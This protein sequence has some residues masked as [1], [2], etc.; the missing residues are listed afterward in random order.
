[1]KSTYIALHDYGAGG[2][3]YRLFA[4]S[5]NDVARLFP[6]PAWKVVREG[7]PGCPSLLPELNLLESD[8]DEPEDW[9]QKH[10]WRLSQQKMGRLPFYFE[11]RVS[12]IYKY[13]E[14]WAE[15]ESQV[16]LR[17]PMLESMMNK[18]QTRE[19]IS[20]MILCDVDNLDSD[21]LDLQI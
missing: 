1:M 17:K 12:G 9:L 15:S 2:V 10:V 8:V 18:C 3:I 16:L 4:H 7:E 14:V 11:F 5:K 21:E 19:I 20:Q 6:P 13:F